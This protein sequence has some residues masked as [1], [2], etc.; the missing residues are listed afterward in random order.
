MKRNETKSKT[1]LD[2]ELSFS[3]HDSICLLLCCLKKSFLLLCWLIDPI[4]MLRLWKRK[5]KSIRWCS[6]FFYLLFNDQWKLITGKEITLDLTW[7]DLLVCCLHLLITFQVI[8]IEKFEK[9]PFLF[10]NLIVGQLMISFRTTS[11]SSSTPINPAAAA[12]T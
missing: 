2:I 11:S 6:T 12:D 5:E 1:R 10:K 4:S 9:R 3:S 7:L 8:K